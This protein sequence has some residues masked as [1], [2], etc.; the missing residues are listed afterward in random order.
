MNNGDKLT[1]VIEHAEKNG[2]KKWWVPEN[3][4]A[5]MSFSERIGFSMT[6]KAFGVMVTVD[7][8]TQ[9]IP[10]QYI[11]LSH[12]FAKKYW[13]E[14]TNTHEVGFDHA[15][16]EIIKIEQTNW[17]YHLQQAVISKDPLDYYYKCL[18]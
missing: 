6:S 18:K 9:V 16:C 17:Q 2:F 1:A 4:T 5:S 3:L 11:L 8:D 7:R 15:T 14:S 12:E 13:G 10:H